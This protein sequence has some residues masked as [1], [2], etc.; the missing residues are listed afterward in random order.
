MIDYLKRSW[1]VVHLDRLA[2]NVGNIR[3]AI[4]ESCMIMGVVKADGYGHGDRFIATE[5]ERLGVNWFGVSGLEEALALRDHGIESPIL[6]FG[7]TP[8][9]YAGTMAAQ[10]IVQTVHTLEYAW[11]LQ[12]AAQL[13]GVTVTVHIKADT[14]MSRL[15]FPVTGE[16]IAAS[17]EEIIQICAMENLE[18]QGFYTHFS[19]ADESARDSAQYT[20]N[21]FALFQ[22]CSQRLGERGISFAIRHCCNSAA[23][24]CYPEMHL[25]MVRPGIILYGLSPSADC[26]GKMDLQPV[27]ELYSRITMVKEI[28][29][30]TAV[31][32]GRRY[33]SAG[34]TKIATVGIGYADGYERQ[35]SNSGRML[36]RGQYAGVVGRVCMDQ[37]MLD[38]TGIDG[39]TQGD[40]VTIVGEDGDTGNAVTFDEMADLTGTINYE[41]VCLIGR[42]VPRVYRKNGRD[43]GAVDYLRGRSQ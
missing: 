43:V 1:A 6:I 39:V 4:S 7:I 21:Q 33:Y 10:G 3:R 26:R 8:A 16:H 19:C 30:G 35:L 24:I 20:R 34:P 5:L 31:S 22:E 42:R 12:N 18:A 9:E 11:A 23:T 14:G 28:D 15:G 37:L 2:H 27:M 13:A 36:V 38:V 29:P 40:V 25:D 32:Y 17:V 41:K